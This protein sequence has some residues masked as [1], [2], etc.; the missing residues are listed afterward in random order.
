MLTTPARHENLGPYWCESGLHIYSDQCGINTKIGVVHQDL[1]GLIPY[2]NMMFDEETFAFSAVLSVAI[3]EQLG[4]LNVWNR[5][6]LAT[7]IFPDLFEDDKVELD[8]EV[9]T[10]TII[11]SFLPHQIQ[12]IVCSVK[13]PFRITGVMH[14]LYRPQPYPHWEYWF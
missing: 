13:N 12:N 3:P 11:D 10:I 8:Y 9:G 4:G 7:N 2:P 6:F 5:R 14:F 1:E